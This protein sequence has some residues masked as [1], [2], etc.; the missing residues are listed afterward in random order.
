MKIYFI[1]ETYF[2]KTS[3]YEVGQENCKRGIQKWLI[4]HGLM[5]T[6]QRF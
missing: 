6:K 1:P 4:T 5:R 2:T 3:T